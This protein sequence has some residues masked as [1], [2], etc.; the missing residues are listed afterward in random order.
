MV[1]QQ[2]G[3]SRERRS[4]RGRQA[5]YREAI[6]AG[7]AGRK[8]DGVRVRDADTHIESAGEEVED[9]DPHRGIEPR[10]LAEARGK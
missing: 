10:S 7:I 5:A 3:M 1:R 9:R 6:G 4:R 8:G 2:W